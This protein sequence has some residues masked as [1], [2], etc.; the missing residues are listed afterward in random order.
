[1]KKEVLFRLAKHITFLEDELKDHEIFKNLSWEDY[2]QYRS[3]RREVERWA[4]NIINSSIDVSKIILASEG[5]PLADTYKD[6]V[7]SLSLVSGFDKEAMEKL[8]GYVKL[9][10]IITHEYLD[11]RWSSIKKFISEA[12]PFYNE[13]V[14]DVKKYLDMKMK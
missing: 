6:I 9:R 2:N 7:S 14:S 1:M 10:N 11:L 12:T 4:E 5:L 8:S 13:L 3:K